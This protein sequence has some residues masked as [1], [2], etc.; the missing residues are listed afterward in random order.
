MRGSEGEG[1]GVKEREGEGG[2]RREGGGRREEEG[3]V[4]GWVAYSWFFWVFLRKAVCVAFE[5]FKG[6]CKEFIMKEWLISWMVC[7]GVGFI[8]GW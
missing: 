2:R 3:G 4:D 7:E 6:F 5:F 1:R 8:E